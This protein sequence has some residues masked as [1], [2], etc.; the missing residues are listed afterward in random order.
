MDKY[1]IAVRRDRRADVG[2]E[3]A[4]SLAEMQDLKI[5]GSANPYRLRVEASEA[6]IAAARKT[7]ESFCYIEPL[8]RR[9]PLAG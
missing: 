8:K 2:P 5:V 3:W 7:L 1:V 6:A 9:M 4:R